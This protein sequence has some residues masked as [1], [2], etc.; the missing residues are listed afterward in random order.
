ME[1]WPEP[2]AFRPAGADLALFPEQLFELLVPV[3]DHARP[4]GRFVVALDHHESPVGRDVVARDAEARAVAVFAP[5]Q[6][7]RFAE[8]RRRA[9][10]DRHRH[11]LVAIA[12]EELPAVAAPPRMRAAVAR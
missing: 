6:Q 2:P 10:R 1:R 3:D 7:C 4:I 8:T 12:I 9:W 5:E 11:H